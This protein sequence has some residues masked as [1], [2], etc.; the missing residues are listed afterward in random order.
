MS[1]HKIVIAGFGGAGQCVADVATADGRG[2]IVGAFDPAARGIDKAREL[3]PDAVAGDDY[4]AI[5]KK[6]KPDAVVIS[7]PDHLHADQAVLALE[8]GAHVLVEKPLTTTV[9]DARRVIE[10]A[11][12]N[13]LQVMTDHTMRY[14]FPYREYAFAAKDG[15]VGKIFF[16]QGNYIHDMWEYYA[17]EG[18]CHTPWRI[19][20]DNP[21]NIL[22]GGGCHG[23][24]LMLWT[25]GQPCVEVTAYSNKFCVPQF[26]ADDCYLVM[27]KF[28]DGALGKCFVSSGCAG[29]G[30]GEFL[31]VYGTT[32]TLSGGKCIRRNSDE[33][34]ELENI[35]D[36]NISGGHG[37]GGTVVDFLDTLDGA[38][39][40]PIP[41]REGANVVAVCEAALKSI[42]SGKP[43]TVDWFQ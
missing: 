16:V 40:N 9:A 35:S 42:K 18:V 15:R 33:T 25:V 23:I 2:S 37:W 36:A 32:G 8:C 6:T 31:E 12:K 19:D 27:M 11:R 43:E 14:C 7:G 17:P 22:L 30:Q 29:G 28:Q 4:E 26:P 24:D 21:Q 13:N 41:A 20:K 10:C 1:N 34:T 5:L 3:Y 39:E 38:I